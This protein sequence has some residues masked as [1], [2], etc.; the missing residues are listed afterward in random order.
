M[1]PAAVLGDVAMNMLS[2]LA[3]V[4]NT[5][6]DAA[7]IEHQRPLVEIGGSPAST[8]RQTSSGRR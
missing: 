1:A 4:E 2:E 3:R 8:R 7:I 6:E 5:V